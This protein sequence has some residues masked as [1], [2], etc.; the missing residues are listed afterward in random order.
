VAKIRIPKTTLY[1]KVDQ[2]S[3]S[4]LNSE[5]GRGS[6]RRG[7][8]AL[9]GVLLLVGFAP[10]L[11]A[12]EK[13]SRLLRVVGL[14]TQVEPASLTIATT[15]GREVTLT[16]QEDFS[17][18]VGVG[19]NVTASY[20]VESGSN[21]LEFL[22]YGQEKGSQIH[23]SIKKIILLPSSSVPDADGVF[24]AI[25]KYLG[26]RFG[27][28]VAP[29]VLAE[30]I[31]N[32]TGKSATPLDAMNPETGEFD[33][34]MYLGRQ[35]NLVT[36][37]ASE[38]RVDA[39]LEASVEQVMAKVSRRVASWDGNEEVIGGKGS[40]TVARV[41]IVPR[42]GE[43]SASTVVLKLWDAQGK[44]LWSNRRGFA[45]LEVLEGGKLRYR[46]LPEYLEDSASVERWLRAVFG[47]LPAEVAPDQSM[48]GKPKQS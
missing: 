8:S 1:V 38:T 41:A 30:E 10:G 35:Q 22:E 13:D 29:R 20:L 18:R 43:V 24:D 21:L 11:Q 7:A 32:R 5:L 12:Q 33:M 34:A 27:W 4:S 47:S 25:E 16:T 40:R 31:R 36:K 23:S 3:R 42:K 46:S 45:A 6:P 17:K 2:V 15:D 37:L 14:V 9:L 26:S 28:Y 44:L 48:A 19:S 39:V